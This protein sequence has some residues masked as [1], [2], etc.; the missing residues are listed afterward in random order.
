MTLDIIKLYLNTP[1]ARYKYVRLK[2]EYLPEDVIEGWK[3][4]EKVT[5]YIYVYVEVRKG[6]YG[7]P[8][9]EIIVH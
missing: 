9:S 5:K 7:F 2:M 1:L 4:Y 6:M 8:H 3:L